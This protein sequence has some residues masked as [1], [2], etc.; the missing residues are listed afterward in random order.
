MQRELE[1]AAEA[2]SPAVV[3]CDRGT[4]DGEAYW[5]GPGDLWS[6]VG[7]TLPE[8]LER[9]GAVIRLRTPSLEGGY[10]QGNQ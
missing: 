7:A 8:Q 10:N 1:A 3:L 2:L 6:A 4:V 9:Y 5:P